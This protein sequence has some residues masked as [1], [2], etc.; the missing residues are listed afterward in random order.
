MSAT[1]HAPDAHAASSKAHHGL[2]LMPFFLALLALTAAEVGLYEGWRHS[3]KELVIK[4]PDAAQEYEHDWTKE[5]GED[6]VATSTWTATGLTTSNPSA[7]GP[8]TKVTLAGGA[9]NE[10]YSL[11]N[12]VTTAAGKKLE[13]RVDVEVRGAVVAKPAVDIEKLF[14][15][16]KFVLVLLILVFTLPKAYLVLV[17]FMHIRFEKALVVWLAVVPLMMTFLAVLPTLTDTATLKPR[18]INRVQ[19][20][21]HYGGGHDHGPIIIEGDH[22]GKEKSNDKKKAADEDDYK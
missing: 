12:E 20:I 9:A 8:K 5:L 22:G 17:Y 1:T 10:R 19:S 4:A 6:S 14:F 16:P 3:A 13:Y 21:G 2:R 18:K 7:H 11:V 15:I